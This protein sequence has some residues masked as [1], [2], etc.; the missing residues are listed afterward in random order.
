MANG[1]T[2]REIKEMVAQEGAIKMQTAMRLSLDLQAQMFEKME[3]QNR[4]H[5]ELAQRVASVESDLRLKA[6]KEDVEKVEQ[7]SIV[8]WMQKH[9]KLTTAIILGYIFIT[10][11]LDV[12]QVLAYALGMKLP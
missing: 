8:L 12:R 3:L 10:G 6:N 5:I 9:P 7:A 1:E 4:A 11:V 2:L